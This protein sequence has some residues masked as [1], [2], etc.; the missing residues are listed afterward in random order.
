MPARRATRAAVAVRPSN[1][2][3]TSIISGSPSSA[4]AATARR[5]AAADVA[6]VA[7]DAAAVAAANER[8][9]CTTVICDAGT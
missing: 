2:P 8:G 3:N 1:T 9:D 5:T 6:A 4:A 7:A